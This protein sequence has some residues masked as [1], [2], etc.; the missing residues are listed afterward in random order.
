MCRKFNSSDPVDSPAYANAHTIELR[1]ARKDSTEGRT[2]PLSSHRLA[3]RVDANDV[4][5][6]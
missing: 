4:T 5:P 1:T 6:C 3:S 2:V